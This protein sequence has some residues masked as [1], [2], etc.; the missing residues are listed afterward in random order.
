[1]IEVV[2]DEVVEVLEV[3]LLVVD[4]VVARLKVD[5]VEDVVDDEAEV[6]DEYVVIIETSII[7]VVCART[8][9]DPIHPTLDITTCRIRMIVILPILSI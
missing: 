6:V 8:G 9:S 4:E 2:V 7:G 1:M 3:V 5:E